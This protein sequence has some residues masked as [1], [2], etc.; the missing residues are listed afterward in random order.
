MEEDVNNED[1]DEKE[2]T[3]KNEDEGLIHRDITEN[4]K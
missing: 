4:E 2:T 1:D 3:S